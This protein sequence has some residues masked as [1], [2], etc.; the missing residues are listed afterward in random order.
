V[1]QLEVHWG[2]QQCCVCSLSYI[3][4]WDE[5]IASMWNT[6]DEGCSILFL[7]STWIVDS[8]DQFGWLSPSQECNSSI[9]GR[10]IQWNTFIFHKCGTYGQHVIVSHSDRPLDVCVESEVCTKNNRRHLSQYQIVV[11][12]R[13]MRAPGLSTSDVSYHW[14]LYVVTIPTQNV[15]CYHPLSLGW[16][17]MWYGRI[18]TWTYD[19][20]WKVPR[21]S[22]YRFMCLELVSH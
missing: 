1:L 22:V 8:C 11:A 19:R 14:T 5:T 21:N 15:L 7:F 20:N 3:W 4:C 12:D 6:F 13:V 17:P 10:I 18:P 16:W 2:S 9:G